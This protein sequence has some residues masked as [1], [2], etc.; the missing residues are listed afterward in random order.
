MKTLKLTLTVAKDMT[1][2]IAIILLAVREPTT[3][4][5][6]YVVEVKTTEAETKLPPPTE[7]GPFYGN[8]SIYGS[9][10]V[11][12]CIHWQ[13]MAGVFQDTCTVFRSTEQDCVNGILSSSSCV[14]YAN[15]QGP[16]CD[17]HDCFEHG[18][19]DISRNLCI[20][21]KD[22]SPSSLCRDKIPPSPTCN[23][24]LCQGKCVED[25]CV[26]TL[27]G[28]L[29]TLCYQ[30]AYPFMDVEKCPGRL[31]WGV[32]HVDVAHG[33]G[34]CGGGYEFTADL[35]LKGKN[36]NEST[37]RDFLSEAPTCCAPGMVCASWQSWTYSPTTP[38]SVPSVFNSATRRRYLSVYTMHRRIKFDGEERNAYA[39]IQNSDW[40]QL[41][42]GALPNRAYTLT[43]LNR[44]LSLESTNDRVTPAIWTDER[45]ALYLRPA[46]EGLHYILYY[47]NPGAFCLSDADASLFMQLQLYGEAGL[48]SRL[49]WRN[50]Q[51]QPGSTFPLTICGL[52]NVEPFRTK[53]GRMLSSV[54]GV[55]TWGSSDWGAVLG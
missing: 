9:L 38:T 28:Q 50:L 29:G 45:V 5:C 53:E 51:D 24:A 12:G 10:T 42:V 44:F 13:Q 27:P 1:L 2:L 25:T 14:C 19:Y 32:E 39:E 30:C 35:V 41:T 40:A 54:K 46:L 55:P 15:W 8:M 3:G 34:V 36:C 33:F 11:H 23:I 20:C 43:L 48:A 26:C 47:A 18:T 22:Y 21:S 37:C 16:V 6:T 52:F 7:P 49:F 4:P 17:I 31:N